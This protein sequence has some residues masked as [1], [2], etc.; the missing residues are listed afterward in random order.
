MA[1]TRTKSLVSLERNQLLRLIK[2][3]EAELADLKKRYG[4]LSAEMGLTKESEFIVDGPTVTF[5]QI[6]DEAR[7]DARPGQAYLSG[8]EVERRL[9]V[10][11]RQ[12][13]AR[14]ARGEVRA[15]QFESDWYYLREDLARAR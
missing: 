8:T 4:E 14:R 1:G 6:R 12:L 3:R 9:G 13:A 2:L 5:K 10:S 15:I 7:T 11:P